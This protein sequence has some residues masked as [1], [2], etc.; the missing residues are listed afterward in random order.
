MSSNMRTYWDT[1]LSVPMSVSVF[2]ERHD[3]VQPTD[4]TMSSASCF[5]LLRIRDIESAFIY[6][7]YTRR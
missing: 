7:F 5:V 4:F 1:V 6:K 2:N 3:D